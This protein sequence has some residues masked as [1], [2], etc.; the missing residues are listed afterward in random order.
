M[1]RVDGV[2]FGARGDVRDRAF[3]REGIGTGGM[4]AVVSLV[5]P[6]V[7]RAA[8]RARPGCLRDP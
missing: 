2:A 7:R 6:T 8:A 3:L 4:N 5:G 1:G